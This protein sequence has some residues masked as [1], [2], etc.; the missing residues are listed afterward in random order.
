MQKKHK[1][2][3]KEGGENIG[4]EHGAVVVAGLG[5]EVFVAFVT[6]FFHF[7]RL[8]ETQTP[9]REH[10][11]LVA[12]WTLDVEDAVSFVA[13]AKNTHVALLLRKIY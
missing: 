3:G 12:F 2:N 6:T 1:T 8:V 5:E 13:F 7:E 9:G 10:V 4:K 11:T